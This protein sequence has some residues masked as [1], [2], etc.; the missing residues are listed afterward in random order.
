MLLDPELD[1][2][3][4]ASL[5]SASGVGPPQHVPRTPSS[6]GRTPAEEA[7]AW[8]SIE[9]KPR[10]GRGRRRLFYPWVGLAW[11]AAGRQ[12]RVVA[13]GQAWGSCRRCSLAATAGRQLNPSAS[14]CPISQPPHRVVLKI[15]GRLSIKLLVWWLASSNPKEQKT[16]L[17]GGVSWRPG[18]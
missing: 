11:A 4:W 1:S 7:P 6:G 15:K 8:P 3:V 17:P 13:R 18:D 12:L 16:L 2:G 10:G 14:A 5:L 9:M